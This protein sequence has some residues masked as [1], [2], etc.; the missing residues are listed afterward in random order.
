[1]EQEILTG[2]IMKK[3]RILYG[4]IAAVLAA[5]IYYYVALPAINIHSA[6]V[7][8]FVLF[9]VAAVGVIYALRKGARRGDLN[10]L[11]EVKKVKGVKIIFGLFFILL[12][13][14]LVGSLLS[15]PIVNA[16][17][18]QQLLKV[19]EGEFTK[20]IEE[21]SFDQIPLLDR[22]SALL[23]GNRKMGS[24]SDM[25]SQ[26]EVDDIYSQINYQDRPVRVSPL[27]YASVIK[28]FTNRS[29]GIPAYIKIDMASQTT[30]LVK[31]KEGM[32]Y[33]TSE[34]FGRN[35]YR[36]LRFA[37]P[38]YIYGELSFEID[39][40]GVPYW[41]APVKK[42]NIGLFGGETVGRVVLCNA[43][44][45]ELQDYKVE[46]VPQWIDRAYSADLLVQLYDYYGALKHGFFNS[47][48]S[49]KDCL[50]TT[51]GYNYLAIDD[52]VWVY[53]G[54]T[55]VNSDQSNVGFVLMNQRTMETKY[56]PIEGA[57]EDSAMDSAEGQVQ[58]LHYQATFPLLLNISGEPTYFLALKDDA[59][60]VKKYAMVNVQ[61]YQVVAIGDTVSACEAQYHELL[62]TNGLREEEKDEREIQSVTGTIERIAQGVVEG[63]S[64]YYIMLADSEEIYDIPVVQFVEIIRYDVGDEISLEYKKGE[65][66]NTVTALKEQ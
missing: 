59:G 39:E 12:A 22:D 43:I 53:T 47:V 9:V 25:V 30:E 34:H 15:S 41:I 19:E 24:M 52:D 6:D 28:W 63:N 27:K 38:T 14:Y 3:R 58:N 20:D 61:K 54:V 4:V 35:V 31:L 42:F 49:Q 26:F 55:S 32:K 65:K 36:H 51:N 64:H 8:Y 56:Y 21:L 16:K 44:T 66:M 18:Y 33:S 17:K 7:W 46:D 37:H 5:G 29:D 62:L 60:L 40:D 13:V 48:L 10:S 23:L 2:E 11:R 1:L 50:K 45:G 57:I